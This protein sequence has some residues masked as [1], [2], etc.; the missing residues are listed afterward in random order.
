MSFTR[1]YNNNDNQPITKVY[2]PIFFASD[3]NGGTS[4]SISY[5]NRLMKITITPK[6]GEAYD[7]DHAL[8]IYLSYNRAKILY[9]LINKLKADPETHNVC[10]E[11]NKGLLL[12][13]DGAE[14]NHNAPCIVIMVNNGTDVS[15][16]TLVYG[17]RPDFHKGAYNYDKGQYVEYIDPMFELD[18]FQ[19]ALFNYYN[20]STYA[21]A[22]SV[23]ESQSYKYQALRDRVYGIAEKVGVVPQYSSNGGGTFLG[24][25]AGISTD[26]SQQSQQNQSTDL[27]GAAKGYETSTFDDIA[28]SMMA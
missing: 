20:A 27:Q 4:L 22:A 8:E 13:S 19:N 23:A 3:F 6:R 14:F 5:F 21:L 26:N 16:T 9:D 10:V 7:K 18:M 17:T 24:G 25:N 28:N 11:T 1:N 15:T 2:S 12:V